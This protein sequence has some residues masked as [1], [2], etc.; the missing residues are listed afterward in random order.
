MKGLLIYNTTLVAVAIGV[1][2]VSTGILSLVSYH[3]TVG[4]E[5]LAETTLVQYNIKLAT[6]YVDR[7]EQKIID[8]D[9]ILSE[10]IDINEPSKWPAMVDAIKKA[11]LNVDQVYV[12]RSNDPYPL[13]PPYS[14]EIRNSWGAFR[15]SFK[16][17][18]IDL[19]RLVINQP[20]HL[21]KE[22]PDNYFFASYVLKEDRKGQ[23]LLVCFQMN[24]DKIIAVIDKYLRDLQPNFYVSIVD[25]DNNGVYNQP[26]SRSG[27][28]FYETRFPS[29]L[30]KWILQ[31]VPRNYTEIE[32][33][34]RN[35]RRTN[36]FLIIISM[37][38]IFFSLAIIY[39]AG[40]RERQ[41]RKLKED[42]ISNVS[43]ELKTP[44]SLIGMFSE[45][46]RSGRVRNEEAKLEYYQ[47]INNECDR[48]SHLISNLLDFASLERGERA[49][50]FETINLGQLVT[51]D[52]EAYRY[53][54]QKDGFQ[55]TS[56]VD[57]DMQDTFADP[58]AISMAFLNL[59]DNSVKY[60]GDQKMIRVVV[61]QKDGH[62]DLSVA[63]QG[64]GIAPEEQERIFDKFY[65]GSA[66]ATGRIRGS[67]IGLSITKHVA[68]MHG[69]EV[70]VTSELG[71][72]STFTLRI[73]IRRPPSLTAEEIAEK[74]EESSTG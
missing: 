28:Y 53:Q 4:R 35:Q 20:H 60:S 6:Q 44:L 32:R 68:E 48:M 49:R 56:E 8:N 73:P 23:K 54:A 59:L 37:S 17:K 72:G 51:K 47:I 18:E 63:D 43:H 7:I 21:H 5:N 27:K 10:M 31:V 74:R 71:K 11:D 2:V 12:L 62:I 64:P 45:I 40:R 30:Y 38:L 41:L 9:L 19:Q 34:V 42:F 66:A 57:P 25:F 69:G 26:I 24:F 46:L 33:D 1:I 3:Y 29:T 13:Y 61:V 55:V 50:N 65:R 36:L 22:R 16:I 14:Y 67:G 39:I 15:S 70:L 58:T 52:L